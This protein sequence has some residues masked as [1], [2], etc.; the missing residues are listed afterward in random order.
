MYR[1]LSYC[2]VKVTEKRS[3]FSPVENLSL[4][5]K[6]IFIKCNR[7]LSQRHAEVT[8]PLSIGQERHCTIVKH[9]NA[10]KKREG[11]MLQQNLLHNKVALLPSF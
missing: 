2:S 10:C 9:H 3:Q 7:A 6:K 1:T 5:T 4:P 11:L 8:T